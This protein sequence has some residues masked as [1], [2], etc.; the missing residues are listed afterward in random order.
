MPPIGKP[1]GTGVCPGKIDNRF[2]A[3]LRG[4]PLGI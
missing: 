2:F 3:I 1:N 4:N